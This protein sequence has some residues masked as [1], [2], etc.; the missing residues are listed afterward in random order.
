MNS[1]ML[2]CAYSNGHIQAYHAFK[3]IIELPHDKTN[4]MAC[5]PS[6][7][8]DQPGHPPSLIRVFA[9]CMKKAWVLHTAKTLIRLGGCPCWSET[10]LGAHAILLVLSWGGSYHW[11]TF[12]CSFCPVFWMISP[13]E[14]VPLIWF[15]TWLCIILF[16]SY[17]TFSDKWQ[18]A[19]KVNIML[20]KKHWMKLAAHKK[21]QPQQQHN[22]NK[23]TTATT[24]TSETDKVGIWW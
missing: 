24:I 5:A 23:T 6:Q 12:C 15:F 9:V 8:S 22:N 1:N 21:Q 16:L 20:A 19:T 11:E 3:C 2:H 13:S 17:P 18:K 10:L 14:T 4:K 7:D